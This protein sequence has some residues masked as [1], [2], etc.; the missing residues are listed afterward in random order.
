MQPQTPHK[1]VNRLLQLDKKY[2]GLFARLK[3]L[4]DAILHPWY[5]IM[6][7]VCIFAAPTVLTFFGISS[8]LTW[9]TGISLLMTMSSAWTAWKEYA[10]YYGLQLELLIWKVITKIHGGPR[11]SWYSSSEPRYEWYV[12]ADMMSRLKVYEETL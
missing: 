2:S 6:V 11:I 1:Q 10:E 4:Y 12:Y 5:T 7:W 9:M 8:K 3:V